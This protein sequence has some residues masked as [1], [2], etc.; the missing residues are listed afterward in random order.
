[1]TLISERSYSRCWGQT[2]QNRTVP[3]AYAALQQL[4]AGQYHV[5]ALYLD[6]TAVCWGDDGFGQSTPP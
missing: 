6:D 4:D 3:N 5:C 2:S 1:M